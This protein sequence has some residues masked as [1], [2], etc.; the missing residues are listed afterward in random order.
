[1]KSFLLVGIGGFLGSYSRY[2]MSY[3]IEQKLLSSFPYGTFFVNIAG[4]FIIGLLFGFS[5]RFNLKPEIRLLLATGFCGG[6]TTFSTFSY[7]GIALL[8]DA[9]IWYGFLYAFSSLLAGFL[10]VWLGLILTRSL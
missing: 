3:Y 5:F 1:M 8:Q 2:I 9:Q 7:E 6:F 10:A 4:C